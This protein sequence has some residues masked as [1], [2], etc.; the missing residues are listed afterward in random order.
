M[1][2]IVTALVINVA[3]QVIGIIIVDLLRIAAK[4]LSNKR[5]HHF[6]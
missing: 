5:S 1:S 4:K 2:P 6:H 3:A